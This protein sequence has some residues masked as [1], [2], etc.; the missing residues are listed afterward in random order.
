[1][2]SAAERIVSRKHKRE[3]ERAAAVAWLRAKLDEMGLEASATMLGVDAANLGKTIEGK[4]RPS[5]A[6]LAEIAAVR[7]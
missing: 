3:D 6:L 1:M 4:R 7:S 5:G 2:A